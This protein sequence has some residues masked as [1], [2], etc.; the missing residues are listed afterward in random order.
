MH[1]AGQAGGYPSFHYPTGNGDQG[2]QLLQGYAL[3]Q[4][5]APGPVPGSMFGGQSAGSYNF[6]QNSGYSQ[7]SSVPVCQVEGVTQVPMQHGLI[8][9]F[10]HF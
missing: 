1:Q 6:D 7:S 10:L 9:L 3:S 2:A 5:N 4:G 8:F